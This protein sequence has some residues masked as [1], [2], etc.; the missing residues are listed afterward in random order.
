M[1]EWS[2]GPLPRHYREGVHVSAHFQVSV[3]GHPEP[4]VGVISG[5]NGV[6]SSIVAFGVP[7]GWRFRRGFERLRPRPAQML[8]TQGLNVDNML[9][10]VCSPKCCFNMFNILRDPYHRKNFVKK[11]SS[12]YVLPFFLAR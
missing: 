1:F 7:F 6:I 8:K 10:V 2:P 9:D 3:Q 5:E 12:T 4:R 11:I